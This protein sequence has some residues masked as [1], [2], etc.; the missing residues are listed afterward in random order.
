MIFVVT[1]FLICEHKQIESRIWTC[2][3]RVYT[4]A[5]YQLSH[6]SLCRQSTFFPLSLLVGSDWTNEC[7]RAPM[8]WYNLGSGTLGI[9]FVCK[10]LLIMK[11]FLNFH[12]IYL[13]KFTKHF[14]LDYSELILYLPSCIIA[15]LWSCLHSVNSMRFNR[16]QW[17]SNDNHVDTFVFSGAQ[18]PGDYGYISPSNNFRGGWPT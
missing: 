3:L 10:D 1:N 4:P 7:C 14:I 12:N 13:S 2:N 9:N 11:T 17:L 5:L 8:L 18:I 6:L 16:C 15:I